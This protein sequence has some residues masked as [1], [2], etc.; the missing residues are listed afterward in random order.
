MQAMQRMRRSYRS[1]A[2]TS[3]TGVTINRTGLRRTAPV[4]RFDDELKG[5][6]RGNYPQLTK[7]M[8][9]S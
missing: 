6:R 3:T 4:F 2:T 9:S 7:G 5:V 8:N 1:A